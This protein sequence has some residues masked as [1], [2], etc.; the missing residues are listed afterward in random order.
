MTLAFDAA[1][2]GRP[3]LLLH[4]TAADRRMWDPL[5]PPL[6]EAGFRTIRCDLRG[7]G[8]TPAADRPCNDAD[9]VLAL[10]DDLGVPQAA[11]VA[12]SGGG[13]VALEIA[14]RHPARVTALAL[15]CSAAPGHEPSASLRAVWERE[16]ALLSAGDIRAAVELNVGTWLGPAAGDEA[17]QLL[18]T[19]QQRI[20]DLGEPT[21]EPLRHEYELS[22]ITAPALLVT[23]AHDL[24]DFRQI[25]DRLAATLPSATRLDLDWAGHLPTLERPDLATPILL[26]FLAR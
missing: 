12:S 24:P 7:Y 11:V 18:R 23:G 10:L 26:D 19:M 20:F 6:A 21:V 9:D 15:F 25:A 8:D 14:A 4:S 5:V 2:A 13:R 3:V 1:G 22:A 16:E 17:R